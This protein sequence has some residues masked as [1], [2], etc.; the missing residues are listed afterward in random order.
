MS[1]RN[2][3]LKIVWWIDHLGYGGSQKVLSGLI[4]GVSEITTNQTIVCLNNRVDLKLLQQIEKLGVEVRIS[5][6]LKLVTGITLIQTWWW[7]RRNKHDV[8]VTF[9]YFSDIVGLFVSRLCGVSRLI[10]SQESSNNH[11]TE[12]HCRLLRY[13][14]KLANVIVLNNDSY[15]R[16]IS[17]Y[18]PVD[19][20]VRVIPNGLDLAD[21]GCNVNESNIRRNLKLPDGTC[22]I[23]SIGR[24]SREKGLDILIDSLGLLDQVNVH[25]LIIGD[26]NEKDQLEK[27]AEKLGLSDR[28]HMLGYRT[29]IKELLNTLTVCVQPSRF[30]GMPMV[31]LEAMVMGCP[32]VATTVGGVPQMIRD[33]VDGWLVPPQDSK[34]LAI[35]VSNVLADPIEAHKRAISAR[36]RIVEEFSLGRQVEAWKEVL[37]DRGCTSSESFGHEVA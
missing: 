23:G 20:E 13:T 35:A 27:Q 9:L 34:Q 16:E 21:Y 29:D 24:L 1:S 4:K 28:V 12:W 26:G 37:G 30:E 19:S 33:G 5:N 11:Y 18:I 7:L 6:K 8:A 31:I 3:G 2:A 25:L 36:N 10:S 15:S 32:V 17:R 22:L 14:L